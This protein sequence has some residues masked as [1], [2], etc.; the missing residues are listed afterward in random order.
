[1]IVDK[2]IIQSGDFFEIFDYERP[3]LVYSDKP[4]YRSTSSSLNLRRLIMSNLYRWR[5]SKGKVL[6]PIFLTLTH[7]EQTISL[8]D[9][10]RRYR[11]FMVKFQKYCRVSGIS[12]LKYVG[13]MEFT[14]AGVPHYHILFFN[15]PYIE[16]MRFFGDLWS[17]GYYVFKVVR[18]S[19]DSTARYMAK[20][21]GKGMDSDE[22]GY[23]SYY[24]AKGLL[25][26][27]SYLAADV[28]RVLEERIAECGFEVIDEY[29]YISN[30]NGMV[31]YRLIQAD[32]TLMHRTSLDF[33]FS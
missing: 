19:Y 10:R 28:V 30:A 5:D 11:A 12:S 20:Y 2:K 26:P 1:M 31:Y 22:Q 3:S 6:K 15:L 29:R 33:W 25:K 4:L 17:H 16:D 18:D 32:L 23:D 24:C 27:I 8:A 7:R 13:V 21:L 14:K 9:S